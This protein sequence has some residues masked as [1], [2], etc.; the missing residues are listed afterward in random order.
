MNYLN[1]FRGKNTPMPPK[2]KFSEVIFAWFGGFIAI[3]LIGYLTQQYDSYLSWVRL[4]LRA[5]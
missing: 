5:S 4:V 1:K 3:A 2:T